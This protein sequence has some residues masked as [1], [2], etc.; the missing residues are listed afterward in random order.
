M[1]ESYSKTEVDA[2][3]E[4]VEERID[5]SLTKMS[6]E[7]QKGFVM[8]EKDIAWLKALMILGLGLL[9]GLLFKH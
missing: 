6:A 9:F 8:V 2:K 4:S 3:L 1:S 7:I 5:H